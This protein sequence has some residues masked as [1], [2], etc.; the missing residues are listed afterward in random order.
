[1]SGDAILYHLRYSLEPGAGVCLWSNDAITDAT[2]GC[3]VDLDSVP[4][5]PLLRERGEALMARF[6]T[7]IDWNYPPDPSPWSTQER[8]RFE[9]DSDDFLGALRSSL[10]GKFVIT[11]RKRE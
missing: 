5:T 10:S 3:A 2:F 4:I 7:S 8:A 1:M 6:D 11:Q 9:A